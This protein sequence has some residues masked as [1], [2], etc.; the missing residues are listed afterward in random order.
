LSK[1]FDVDSED[2]KSSGNEMTDVSPLTT[3]K[4]TAGL[5]MNVFYKALEKDLNSANL[6]KSPKRS[7]LKKSHSLENNKSHA[8]V[9]MDTS[10]DYD[11]AY[12]SHVNNSLD[13]ECE[14][15]YKINPMTQKMM[16]HN[17]ENKRLY[18]KIIKPGSFV[19]PY[20]EPRPFRLTSSALNRQREQQ[21]IERENQQI[22]KRLLHVK[23]SKHVVK[24]E[25]LKDY[26]KN[27]GLSSLNYSKLAPVPGNYSQANSIAGF[28]SQSGV[29]TKR[30]SHRSNVNSRCSSA[31][32]NAR[33]TRTDSRMS[34]VSH[35]SI[36]P[37]Y[38]LRR[39]N[40]ASRRPQWNDKW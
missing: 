13:L 2:S 34:N 18:E 15:N 40:S 8:H 17:T 1:T 5:S 38:L 23:A 4:E 21:R 39:A 12:S 9:K 24:E 32:S 10:C 22:L 7:V 28:D 20:S 29:S 35:Q 31:K 19:S 26:E 25:Q 3:P 30:N 36:D 27:F 16:Q 37:N 6:Q 33:E 11:Y 14:L